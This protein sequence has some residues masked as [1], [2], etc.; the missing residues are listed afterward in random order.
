[1]GNA[2]S[3]VRHG[4]SETENANAS[5]HFPGKLEPMSNWKQYKKPL[6]LARVV[7][8]YSIEGCCVKA[9]SGNL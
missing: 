2:V 5:T 8:K 7:G 1:V 6:S 3:I 4:E 9:V